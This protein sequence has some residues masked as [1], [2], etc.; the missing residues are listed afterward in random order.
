VK[1][2][3]YV[4]DDPEHLT[5]SYR[6]KSE[7]KWQVRDPQIPKSRWWNT[8]SPYVGFRLVSPIKEYTKE[9]VEAY[10]AKAIVD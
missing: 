4:D 8:D 10:F 1:G 9:E 2:G 6:L 7:A 5:I 3:S